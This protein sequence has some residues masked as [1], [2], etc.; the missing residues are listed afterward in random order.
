MG[1]G[2][3]V[4]CPDGACT[5]LAVWVGATPPVSPFP[6]FRTLTLLQGLGA[7]SEQ[8]SVLHC[9]SPWKSVYTREINS[10]QT[11][12]VPGKQAMSAWFGNLLGG[13][14]DSF[15]LERVWASLQSKARPQSAAGPSQSLAAR[16]AGVASDLATGLGQKE[17]AGLIVY[18]GSVLP[19]CSGPALRVPSPAK[20][21]ERKESA[22]KR[23][24]LGP[25]SRMCVGNLNW[26]GGVGGPYYVWVA[27]SLTEL[28]RKALGW[29][30]WET[31]FWLRGG[32]AQCFGLTCFSWMASYLTRQPFGAGGGR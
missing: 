20:T 27:Q 5:A 14:G 32:I 28:S 10:P 19:L 6:C 30:V 21:S 9:S 11:L 15:C 3:W 2:T 24:S 7:V 4:P 22:W 25:P 1:T 23:L 16:C 8:P 29:A 17:S 31:V 13:I 26:G 12:A 18:K